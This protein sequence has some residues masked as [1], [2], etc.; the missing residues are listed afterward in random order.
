M[1][2]INWQ[3]STIVFLGLFIGTFSGATHSLEWNFPIHYDVLVVIHVIFPLVVIFLA[4][5]EISKKK[6]SYLIGVMMASYLIGYE[7]MNLILERY[8]FD[9]VVWGCLI[10]TIIY[11]AIA[12]GINFL[13][14][15]IKTRKVMIIIISAFLLLELAVTA[16]YC[17]SKVKEEKER[18]QR[19]LRELQ[20]IGRKMRSEGFPEDFKDKK[21]DNK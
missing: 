11:I 8:F 1:K 18:K 4:L 17:Y 10:V 2:I 21:T 5:T 20:E 3:T 15:K 13:K 14:D 6:L 16:H 9:D 19:V 7:V 12:L